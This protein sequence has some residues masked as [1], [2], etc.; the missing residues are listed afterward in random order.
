MKIVKEFSDVFAISDTELT[1]TIFVSHDIGIGTHSRIRPK[2]RPVP[3]SIWSEVDRMLQELKEREVIEVSHSPWA[4]PL[5][6]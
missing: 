1:Q 4:S 6:L 5:Y 2:T 3:Y